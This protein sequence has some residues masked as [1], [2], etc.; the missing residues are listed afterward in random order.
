M[1]QFDH[2]VSLT[3]ENTCN[4]SI[5][6]VQQLKIVS[7]ANANNHLLTEQT[8]ARAGW[9]RSVCLSKPTVSSQFHNLNVF[10]V[11]ASSLFKSLLKA[12][13]KKQPKTN[14]LS[15]SI[16]GRLFHVNSAQNFVLNLSIITNFALN[17][18]TSPGRAAWGTQNFLVKERQS[19][20][21]PD[22]LW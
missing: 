15:S 1:E 8:I 16:K 14:E 21:A 2:T 12:K 4:H 18:Q 13:G 10:S 20:Q 5:S 3:S 6:S 7:H 9:S 19:V 17:H 22:G 11:F